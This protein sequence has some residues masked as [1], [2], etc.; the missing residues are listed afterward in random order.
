MGIVL[1]IFSFPL[2]L[3][4][5]ATAQPNTAHVASGSLGGTLTCP[6]GDSSSAT[7]L[8]GVEDYHDYQGITYTGGNSRLAAPQVGGVDGVLTDGHVGEKSF[9]VTG[10]E[11]I[12]NDCNTLTSDVVTSGKCGIDVTVLYKAEDKVIG[13]FTGYVDCFTRQSA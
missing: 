10:S 13:R 4:E 6:N 11:V 9:R 5:D 8:F 2:V 3:S 1:I 12:G 7:L